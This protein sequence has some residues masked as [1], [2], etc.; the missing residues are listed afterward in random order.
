M[1]NKKFNYP[2]EQTL[3]KMDHKLAKV[4]GSAHTS[5]NANPV[6]ILKN[7]LC[8]EFVRYHIEHEINQRE[9]SKILGLSEARTSEILHYR[10]VRF[11]VDHLMK[12]LAKIK[13]NL[14]VKVA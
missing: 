1:A 10:H 6:D 12:Y 3:K 2:S 7:D 5:S 8:A 4:K 9:L 11:T 14:K 13:P